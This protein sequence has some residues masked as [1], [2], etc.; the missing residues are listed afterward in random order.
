VVSR[1][2]LCSSFDSRAA[3]LTLASGI[4]SRAAKVSSRS[5]A[6]RSLRRI[7]QRLVRAA[8]CFRV[9]VWGWRSF[10]PVSGSRAGISP[11]GSPPTT[12]RGRVKPPP[13]TDNLPPRRCGHLLASARARWTPYAGRTPR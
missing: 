4:P 2:D 5:I 1:P 13:A 7:C 3:A 9:R 8:E 12:H 6:F 10:A 11:P